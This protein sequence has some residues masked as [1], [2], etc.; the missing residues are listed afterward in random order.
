[1]PCQQVGGV[2]GASARCAPCQPVGG[3]SSASHQAGEAWNVVIPIHISIN[4]SRP[5]CA[6]LCPHHS[7]PLPHAGIASTSK[8]AFYRRNKVQTFRE[9]LCVLYYFNLYVFTSCPLLSINRFPVGYILCMLHL[10][11]NESSSMQSETES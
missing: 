7:C 6:A 3:V 10:G 2:S 4:P 1:M 11:L 5:W 9:G 8:A